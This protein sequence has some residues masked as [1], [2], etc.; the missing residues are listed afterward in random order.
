MVYVCTYVVPL[1]SVASDWV[2][3]YQEDPYPAMGELVQLFFSYSGCTAHLDQDSFDDLDAGVTT[4]ELAALENFPQDGSYPIISSTSVKMK[5]YLDEFI[6]QLVDQVQNSVLHDGYFL[7]TLVLWL[8]QCCS[9]ALRQLRHTATYTVLKLNTALVGVANKLREEGDITMRQLES[10]KKKSPSKRASGK[11]ELLKKNMTESQAKLNAVESQVNAIVASVFSERYRDVIEDVRGKCVEELGVW[12]KEYNVMF[13]SDQYLKYIGWLLHDKNAEVRLLCLKALQE[14]YNPSLVYHMSMFTAKFKERLLKM[15][16]DINETV[17]VESIKLL[18]QMLQLELLETEEAEQVCLLVYAQN[19]TIAR[20]AGEFL[21]MY[22]FTDELIEA[23]KKMTVPKGKTKPTEN[24]LKL[25]EL[26]RYFVESNIH[27]H[28]IFFVDSLWKATDAIR[29]WTAMISLLQT[30]EKT[31]MVTLNNSEE[32]VLIEFMFSAVQKATGSLV[33]VLGEKKRVVSRRDREAHEAERHE[34]TESLMDHIGDLLVK[35]DSD[36]KKA[37]SLVAIPQFFELELYSELRADKL[38]EGLL[39]Q[40]QE[41]ALKT[42][43]RN[44]MKEVCKTLKKCC[45]TQWACQQI[46]ERGVQA[47]MDDIA[48]RLVQTMKQC[49]DYD[50]ILGDKELA[51]NLTVAVERMAEFSRVFNMLHLNLVTKLTPLMRAVVK[52]LIPAEASSGVVTV[53]LF[54][55]WF[56]VAELEKNKEPDQE[57]MKELRMHIFQFMNYCELI[58]RDDKAP[59]VVQETVVNSLSDLLIISGPQLRK[60]AAHIEALV[61]APSESLQ[62]SMRDFVYNF[63]FN[64][65]LP[66][67]TDDSWEAQE[68]IAQALLAR[69]RM[70]TGF[71]KLVMYK[72]VDLIHAA[73]ILAQYM[74]Y[75]A[76]YGDLIKTTITNCLRRSIANNSYEWSHVVVDALKSEYEDLKDESGMIDT[77]SPQ[78]GD[79]KD[80]AKRFSLFLGMDLVRI[81]YQ[82]VAL[83]RMGVKYSTA[84]DPESQSCPH[85]NFL[86]VLC[87]FSYKLMDVDKEGD[88]GV[89]A[90]MDSSLPEDQRKEKCVKVYRES[91]E[92]KGRARS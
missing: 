83:H 38:F 81:R 41:T 6:Y 64:Q 43:D 91:F 82:V 72:N 67:D 2:E 45:S 14:L 35:Y 80:L 22:Y 10:E 9:S 5:G 11:I 65:D 86:E 66:E 88:N 27:E 57:E 75:Q 21:C 78:W 87:E 4:E 61:V 77:A 71:L 23:A 42:V 90:Y 46:A 85:L 47:M 48:D 1:Q 30:S 52:G 59:P 60:T 89:I 40:L 58:L 62:M 13:L 54:Q 74:R 56:A 68:K 44:V 29:D 92:K 17:A 26:I 8:V 15:R 19:R 16:C 53:Y 39:E 7:E 76:D 20:A 24:E 51:Y 37:A 79:L 84:V 73:P 31:S 36:P 34:L 70:L 28:G 63:V 49:K 55:F 69:R 50:D 18:G 12:I 33:H 32:T 3:R 25:K